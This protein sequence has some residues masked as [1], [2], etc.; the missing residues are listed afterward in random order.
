MR[1]ESKW[2]I[3]QTRVT[4]G[5]NYHPYKGGGGGEGEEVCREENRRAE[6]PGGH[7]EGPVAVLECLKG[8]QLPDAGT[9]QALLAL[10]LYLQPTKPLIYI[11][12]VRPNL[13]S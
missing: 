13:Y 12:E 5:S 2:E 9:A 10:L 8:H 1:T 6:P 3:T 4:E 7:R 11:K